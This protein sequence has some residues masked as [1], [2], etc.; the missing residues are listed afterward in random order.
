M[1]AAVAALKN[2]NRRLPHGSFVSAA[3]DS[4]ETASKG[5]VAHVPS[6]PAKTATPIPQARLTAATMPSA[7]P[8]VTPSEKRSRPRTAS[9]MRKNIAR[10]VGALRTTYHRT[11]P[12]TSSPMEAYLRACLNR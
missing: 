9:S 1:A 5:T 4:S 10:N 11:P 2:T 12:A 6:S 8:T 3:S 7:M